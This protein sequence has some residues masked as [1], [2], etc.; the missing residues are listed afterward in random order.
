MESQVLLDTGE[1]TDTDMDIRLAQTKV[2]YFVPLCLTCRSKDC[3][4]TCA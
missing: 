3:Y 1:A 2:D 4:R